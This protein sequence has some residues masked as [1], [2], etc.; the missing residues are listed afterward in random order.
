MGLWVCPDVT[1]EVDVVARPQVVGVEGAAQAQDHRGRVWGGEVW[2]VSNGK[3]IH[4]NL[5]MKIVKGMQILQAVGG[6]FNIMMKSFAG[7]ILFV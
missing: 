2:R 3:N 6:A 5:G 1:V 4:R 7:K